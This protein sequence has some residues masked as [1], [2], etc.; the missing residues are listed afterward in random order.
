M[1]FFSLFFTC[2]SFQMLDT[3]DESNYTAVQQWKRHEGRRVKAASFVY[4]INWI[5]LCIQAEIIRCYRSVART[6]RH[7]FGAL[8]QTATWAKKR[9][10]LVLT[11]IR[12]FPLFL[13]SFF[14]CSLFVCLFRWE[15]LQCRAI[16]SAEVKV[17]KKTR[18]SRRCEQ[19]EQPGLS[20]MIKPWISS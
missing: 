9:F 3:P 10:Q 8:R 15:I 13:F 19:S 4:K 2:Y 11:R 6:S 14:F 1:V 5:S 17:F 7:R 18:T 16:L 20:R 12:D